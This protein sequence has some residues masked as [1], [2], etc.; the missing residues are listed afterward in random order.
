M[1][2]SKFHTQPPSVEFKASACR[3]SASVQAVWRSGG[4]ASAVQTWPCGAPNRLPR[5]FENGE[6]VPRP[7]SLSDD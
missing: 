3:V 7:V 6:Q 5:R 4:I 2:R 1:G